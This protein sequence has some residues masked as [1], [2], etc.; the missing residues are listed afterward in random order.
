MGFLTK[1]IHIYCISIITFPFPK[2]SLYKYNQYF[3]RKILIYNSKLNKEVYSF[4]C[5][6]KDGFSK[7][8]KPP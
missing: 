8:P 7:I 6:K 3:K 5:I 2:N 4:V 1:N